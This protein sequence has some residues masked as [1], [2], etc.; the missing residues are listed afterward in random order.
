MMRNKT[1]LAL[2]LTTSL[3]APAEAES[4]FG[5]FTSS[6]V[7][8]YADRDSVYRNGSVV[9]VN[10][11]FSHQEG[12]HHKRSIE[13]DCSSNQY[14]TLSAGDYGANGQYLSSPDYDSSWQSFSD[15]M[16][17]TV[18]SFACDGAGGLIYVSDPFGD[19][20]EYWYYYYYYDE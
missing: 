5:V 9:G 16:S 3:T 14:R 15:G 19:A 12:D 8:A 4:W 11:Q 2:T 6:E 17:A 13:L 10:I 20:D 18:K 7:I 1:L